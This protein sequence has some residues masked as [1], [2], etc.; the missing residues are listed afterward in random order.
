ML[1][2]SIMEK[3]YSYP[4]VNLF[5]K[6]VGTDGNYHLLFS[7]FL[8]VKTLHDTLYFVEKKSEGFYIETNLQIDLESN[9]IYRTYLS[10]LNYL[11]PH[12]KK[13]VE[14]FFKF[15]TLKL[16]KR[17]P[18]MAGLG[19]GSSNSATF[20]NMVDGV[21]GL[22]L[23]IHEKLEIVKNIGSDI[24]FFL[25]DID[26]ANV[27]GKGEI[28][29]KFDEVVPEIE[30]FTPPVQ[31]STSEVYRVFRKKF[32]KLT[33]IEELE[34]WREIPSLEIFKSLNIESAND[35]YRPAKYLCPE[36]K[37]FQ[38]EEYL[39]SGSGSSFFKFKE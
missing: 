2:F 14:E 26:S 15:H 36:L 23:D 4:K 21:L 29:E 5:L 16:E 12:H 7:R 28:I 25:Y 37:K 30:V 20:L 18:T 33:P 38:K 31:C 35:L 32:F 13:R 9:T 3:F 1:E 27:S 6:I 10:L 39:F 22:N 34:K 17:I 19:G 8:R 11:Q 24:P